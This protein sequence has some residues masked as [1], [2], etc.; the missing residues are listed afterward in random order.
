MLL[1][2]HNTHHMHRFMAAVRDSLQRGTFAA[3]RQHFEEEYD[4]EAFAAE[5]LI[6]ERPRSPRFSPGWESPPA[7]EAS[8]PSAASDQ[9]VAMSD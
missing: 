7:K 6:T 1:E 8:K 3:L 4:A 9:E 5:P 2:Y